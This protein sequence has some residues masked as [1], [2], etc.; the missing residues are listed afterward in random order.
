M[1]NSTNDSASQPSNTTNK[2][3]NTSQ[4]EITKSEED[5]L[6]KLMSECDFASSNAEKFMEKLQQELIYLDT[7]IKIFHEMRLKNINH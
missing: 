5:S 7:V 6:L 1:N 4:Y 3:A 2:T